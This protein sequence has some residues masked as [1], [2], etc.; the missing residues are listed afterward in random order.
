LVSFSY[1]PLSVV[2]LI[3]YYPRSLVKL[4]RLRLG[5]FPGGPTPKKRAKIYNPRFYN[6]RLIDFVG[7]SLPIYMREQ[8][9][10][11]HFSTYNI[12]L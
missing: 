12:G 4:G 11:A 10:I 3:L 2:F 9:R 5:D 6:P 1:Y 7:D 8:W